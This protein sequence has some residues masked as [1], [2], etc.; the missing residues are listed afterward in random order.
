MNHRHP[1]PAPHAARPRQSGVTL[2]ESLIV[3]SVMAVLVGAAVPGFEAARERRH[4]EG[5]AAQLETDIHLARSLSVLQ[6]RS[7]RLSV[8]EGAGGSCYLVHTGAVDDCR[9]TVGQAPVC[10][11]GAQA[12][13]AEHQPAGERPQVE[14]NVRSIL[15][16]ATR[17][18]STPTGTFRVTGRGGKAV[19]LVVN[20]M[21]RVRACTPTPGLSGYA[22]C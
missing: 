9:C 13:R 14:A 8:H 1:Q 11:A 12:M 5:T 22:A 3:M 10:T 4:L 6:N 19:H 18:T 20:I 2:V 21:G 17:G 7:L 16:D 15:F